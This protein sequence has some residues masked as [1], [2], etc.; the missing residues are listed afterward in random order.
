MQVMF[1]TSFFS[2]AIA[3]LSR[4]KDKFMQKFFIPRSITIDW[5]QITT[6]HNVG[7]LVGSESQ[8]QGR[9]AA[10]ES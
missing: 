7:V 3:F 2:G 4:S 10:C 9:K 1:L 5:T 6:S 8:K